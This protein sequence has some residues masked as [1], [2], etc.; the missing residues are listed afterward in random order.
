MNDFVWGCPYIMPAKQ[1]K[2][3]L[4]SLTTMGEGLKNRLKI[5]DL[6]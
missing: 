1:E 3:T 4:E 5:I 2:K 6:I